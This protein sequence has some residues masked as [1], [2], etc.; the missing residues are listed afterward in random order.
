MVQVLKSKVLVT[1][2]AGF[3][4]SHL[5]QE[6]VSNGYSVSVLDNLSTGKLDRIKP[7]IS[8]SSATFIN[9]DIR[10]LETVRSAVLGVDSVVHLAAIKDI[11]FSIKNPS[12]TFDVNTVGTKNLLDACV[13]SGVRRFV[14]I[15]TSAVYGNARYLPIDEGHPLNPLSVYADSKI[16]PESWCISPELSGKLETVVFRL[17]NVYGQGQGADGYSGVISKFIDRLNAGKPPIVYGD[18]NQTRDFVNVR[19]VVKSVTL[20]L[21]TERV[22]DQIFNIGSGSSVSILE[23]AK[24]LSSLVGKDDLGVIHESP[25]VGEVLHSQASIERARD[26]LGY[27]PTIDLTVGL[28]ELVKTA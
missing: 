5:V 8:N 16:G 9:G 18:G 1:G 19:D 23:L 7:L 25:R 4:G 3:I 21:E 12:L 28:E 20:A 22:R 10:D 15:S 13:N 6:L 14:F 24:L 2:G 17:F 27:D 26:N 11:Q